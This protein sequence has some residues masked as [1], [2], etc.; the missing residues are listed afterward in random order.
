MPTKTAG[1]KRGSQKRELIA[2]NGYKR[3]VK[4]DRRENLVKSLTLA[5]RFPDRKRDSKTKV[6]PGYG[7]QG[8][9]ASTLRPTNKESPGSAQCLL[10]GTLLETKASIL[11]LT[12]PAL[13]FAE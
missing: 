10:C 8:D 3:Y 7:G 2:P 13:I 11:Q 1:S 4:P 6:E 9:M 12:Q 5:V